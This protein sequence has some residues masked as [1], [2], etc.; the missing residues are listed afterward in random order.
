MANTKIPDDPKVFTNHFFYELVSQLNE[1]AEKR[2]LDN[3]DPHGEGIDIEVTIAGYPVSFT[4]FATKL[5][6][7]FA[8]SVNRNALRRITNTYNEL[9]Q[10][11]YD[12]LNEV[13]EIS[14][15]VFDKSFS[16]E[17][18]EKEEEE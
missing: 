8:A 13:E 7:H 12:K 5:E 14:R 3:H 16:E 4:E 17:S 10:K 6:E 15:S 1:E 18:K 9:R 11:I 2:L